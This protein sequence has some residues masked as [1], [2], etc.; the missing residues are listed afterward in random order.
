MAMVIGVAVVC[1]R[2]VLPSVKLMD[3]FGEHVDEAGAVSI[4]EESADTD[5]DG[6]VDYNEIS[7]LFREWV[8]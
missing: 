1:L 6:Q 4:I 3:E 5:G 2:L 7:Q 8:D